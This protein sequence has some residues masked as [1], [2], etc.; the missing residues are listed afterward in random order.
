MMHD[1]YDRSA[2]PLATEGTQ[3]MTVSFLRLEVT[4]RHNKSRPFWPAFLSFVIRW[5]A[6]LVIL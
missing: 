5:G 2:L 6:N 3:E 1:N 4:Y